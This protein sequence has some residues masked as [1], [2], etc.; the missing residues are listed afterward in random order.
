MSD[1]VN[2]RIPI[3]ITI[4]ASHL[5]T[6]VVSRDRTLQYD[7]IGAASSPIK[8]DAKMENGVQGRF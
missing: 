7:T 8:I 2:G 5:A 6:W 3:T 4:A 1:A